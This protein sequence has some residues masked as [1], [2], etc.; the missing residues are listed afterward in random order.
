[1]IGIVIAFLF[2]F[3]I[4]VCAA[5]FTQLSMMLDEDERRAKCGKERP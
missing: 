1:M 5:C 4:G 3:M 2:G